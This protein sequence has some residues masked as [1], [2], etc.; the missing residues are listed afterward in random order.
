MIRIER[1]SPPEMFLSSSFQND[2]DM[3]LKY[4]RV[5]AEARR[6]SKAAKSN[7]GGVEFQKLR[8]Q[9]L[10]AAKGK[11]NSDF[12]YKCAYCESR[13]EGELEHFRPKSSARGLN[14]EFSFEHYWWLEFEWRNL[15]HVCTTCNRN[16]ASWFPVEGERARI[17]ATY[18]SLK[19]EH[20]LLIDPCND[21][22]EDHFTYDKIGHIL[23]LTDRG[24]LTIDILK[25]NR[26]HLLRVREAHFSEQLKALRNSKIPSILLSEIESENSELEYLGIRRYAAKI[27]SNDSK[28][29][30]TSTR[31]RFSKYDVMNS[32]VSSF[33]IKNFKRIKNLKLTIADNAAKENK[34]PWTVFLGENGVGKSSILQ[35]I[36]LT[37]SDHNYI[38]NLTNT[39]SILNNTSHSGFVIINTDDE[40]GQLK[41]GFKKGVN[42]VESNFK[43]AANYVI[44]FGS[45][46]IFKQ[47]NLKSEE[48]RKFIRIGNL[49]DHT[50]AISNPEQ[51]MLSLNPKL[52]IN[53]GAIILKA[54]GFERGWRIHRKQNQIFIT[55]GNHT[56]SLEALSD[57]YKSAI[58]VIVN[59]MV[60]LR[61]S[62]SGFDDISG[63]VLIDEIE[64]HLHPKWKLKYVKSFRAAFPK[65]QVFATTH[66]PLC[67]KGLYDGEVVLIKENKNGGIKCITEL[68]SIEGLKAEQILTSEFFGLN[69]TIDP[70]D[71]EEFNRYYYLLSKSKLSEPQK[72]ELMDLQTKVLS[73]RQIGDSLRDELT[74]FAA[75]EVIA[76]QY[77]TGKVLQRDGLKQA[78]VDV[79]MNLLKNKERI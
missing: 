16:K 55:K 62:T 65:I 34:A 69:S 13:T 7:I 9:F 33:E 21:F 23:P 58:S 71:E 6:L 10:G 66:D 17:G 25:L 51:W 3:L 67:L 27:W 19:N 30:P 29:N 28:I 54:L 52:F 42:R 11:L 15:Y 40:F 53:A 12:H 47:K 73:K 45:T 60:A 14:G 4:S 38:E 72:K 18:E 44:G 22:P 61:K 1:K 37:L 32:Y 35:A 36:S 24:K 39:K 78:T 76:K 56:H 5:E 63:I 48:N 41:I 64:L 70:E 77:L 57:G 43:R 74:L 49:F 20:Y 68:P 46:R 2:V 31:R 59:V 75:D 8:R 26:P 79:L 50:V